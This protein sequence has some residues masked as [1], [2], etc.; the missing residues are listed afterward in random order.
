MRSKHEFRSAL[1]NFSQSLSRSVSDSTGQWA[2]KGFID[3]YKNIYAI[4]SDTKLVSK[5][6]EIHLLPKVLQFAEQNGFAV[7]LPETRTTIPT[8]HL[9]Q[10]TSSQQSMPWTSRQPIDY[11]TSHGCATDLLL[12]RMADIS[13]IAGAPRISSLPMANTLGTSA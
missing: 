1:T 2:I 12:G 10:R 11:P 6:L 9:L 8:Y 4:S 3:I 5:I 7:V 13:K